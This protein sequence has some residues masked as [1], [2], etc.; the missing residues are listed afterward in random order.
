MLVKF[1][2]IRMVQTRQKFEVF[3]KTKT[4]FFKNH[5]WQI[6][7]AIL[8]DISVLLKQLF[9]AKL[10]ISRLPSFSVS[11]ITLVRHV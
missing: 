9:I 10:L 2:Q 3:D 4:V 7:D 6:V 11:K 8:E 1:E 5:F